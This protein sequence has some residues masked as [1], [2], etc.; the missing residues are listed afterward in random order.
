MQERG[1]QQCSHG[2][3]V[4]IRMDLLRAFPVRT[5]SRCCQLCALIQ[6][7]S[8]KQFWEREST[9]IVDKEYTHTSLEGEE[10]VRQFN[11]RLKF[12]DERT[13]AVE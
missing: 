2:T 13:I 11:G 5:V 4:Y 1:N 3:R 12:D 7:L 6:L 8:V 10:C 9:G